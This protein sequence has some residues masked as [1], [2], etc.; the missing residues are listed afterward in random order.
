M[1]SLRWWLSIALY[2]GLGRAVAGSGSTSGDVT[3]TDTTVSTNLLSNPSWEDGLSPWSYYYPRTTTTAQAIDGSQSLLTSGVYPFQY[4]YQTISGL[5]PGTTYQASVDFMVVITNAAIT[6]FCTVDLYHD[7]ASA[8]NLINGNT[9]S[10][11]STNSQW[12]TLSGPFTA[13]TESHIFGIYITCSPYRIAQVAIYIDNA[14][15]ILD[16]TTQACTTTTRTSTPTSTPPASTPSPQPSSPIPSIASSSPIAHSSSAILISTST[17]LLQSSSPVLPSS[18]PSQIPSASTPSPQP[19]S[20]VSSIASSSPIAHSSSTAPIYP[21][22]SFNPSR[23][24][25]FAPTSTPLLPSSSSVSPSSVPPTSPPINPHT[26]VSSVSSQSIGHGSSPV[27]PSAPPSVSTGSNSLAATT[28]TATSTELQSTPPISNPVGIS[29][30]SSSTISFVPSSSSTLDPFS[31]TVISTESNQQLPSTGPLEPNSSPPPIDLPSTTSSGHITS[32]NVELTTST[33]YSTRTSTITACPSSIIYCPARSRTTYVTTE[34]IY[35]STTVCPV[36]ENE[37]TA[38]VTTELAALTTV[39]VITEKVTSLPTGIPFISVS[40][41][42]ILSTRTATFTS[43]PP[44]VTGCSA[45]PAAPQIVTETLLVGEST[46]TL[47]ETAVATYPAHPQVGSTAS[48][49]LL[50]SVPVSYTTLS[51]SSTLPKA[52]TSTGT[53]DLPAFNGAELLGHPRSLAQIIISVSI[54]AL[55]LLWL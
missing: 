39:Y 46:Y 2:T 5:V 1:A 17:L 55:A 49:R 11:R 35:V 29:I 26:S 43:C 34:T 41:S 42:P 23:S 30:S 21:S 53:S 28:S 25:T 44:E 33:I 7:S 24:N 48:S 22:S 38:Q 8:A 54:A 10:Y 27:I 32:S 4:I 52:S 16:T 50:S 31:T 19:S 47:S 45:N 6:E 13:T 14:K 12:L 3:C 15:F 40:V 20:L 37:P 18:I 9:A 36:A 51:V